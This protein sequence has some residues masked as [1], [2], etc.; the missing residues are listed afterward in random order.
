[1]QLANHVER[2]LRP[3]RCGFGI[4][5]GA[6]DEAA[7]AID[8][9]I[10]LVAAAREEQRVPPARAKA[11][12][13]DLPGRPREPAQTGCGRLEVLHRLAVG[14]TEHH[15][16][17]CLYI[18]R[19]LRPTAAPIERRRTRVV[20]DI[21]EP[22]RDVANV[23]D[24]AESLLDHDDAGIAPGLMGGREIGRD[25]RAAAGKR[26]HS[27]LDAAGVGDNTGYVRHGAPPSSMGIAIIASAA[28]W[29]IA[30]D[31]RRFAVLGW[32]NTK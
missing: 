8:R 22:P 27:A 21:G 16:E 23:V 1:M 2:R 3:R 12:R 15:R 17:H 26:D 28:N 25:V 19:V 7:P 14:Q 18:I 6:L 31:A 29:A 20:A 13:P 4:G 5:G 9:G 32:C 10:D 24:E 11:D 30:N